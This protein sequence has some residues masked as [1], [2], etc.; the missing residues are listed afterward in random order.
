[1][2]NVNYKE[3]LI[4]IIVDLETKREYNTDVYN[5]LVLKFPHIKRTLDEM[6]QEI[7]LFSIYDTDPIS[8]DFNYK[9]WLEKI[10]NM[11]QTA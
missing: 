10:E 5:G 8:V 6:I 3:Q 1:M 2:D 9:P 11:I 7:K 4:K